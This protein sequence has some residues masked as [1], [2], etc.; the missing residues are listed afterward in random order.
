MYVLVFPALEIAQIMAGVTY[1]LQILFSGNLIP[2]N[3]MP[4]S[5]KWFYYV[6]GSSHVT[7]FIT[8]VQVRSLPWRL[9]L[10]LRCWPGATRCPG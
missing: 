4:A 10:S 1:G 6:I 7:Q 2:V 5:A 9:V 3:Q 8:L